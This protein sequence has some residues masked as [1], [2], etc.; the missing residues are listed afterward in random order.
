MSKGNEIEGDIMGKQTP[1]VRRT[2]NH[3]YEH[4]DSVVVLGMKGGKEMRP[5]LQFGRDVVELLDGSTKGSD[6]VQ[7]TRL[8][9]AT[10]TLERATAKTLADTILRMLADS[11]ESTSEE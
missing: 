1:V 10:M 7:A 11:E 6:N 5:V 8:T 2:T 9:F 4:C 3:I